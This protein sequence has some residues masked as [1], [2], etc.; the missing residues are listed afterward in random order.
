[1][2][3]LN[4]AFGIHCH[5]PVGS[6][7]PEIDRLVDECYLPFLKAAAAHPAFKW[8]VHFSGALLHQ[9]EPRRPELLDELKKMSSRGQLELLGGGLYEPILSTLTEADQ[10]GQIRRFSDYL[11]R[12]AGVRPTGAWLAK[13][14]WE[15]HLCKPLQEAGIKYLMLDDLNVAAAGVPAEDVHGYYLTEDAGHRVSVFPMDEGIKTLISRGFPAVMDYLEGMADEHPGTLVTY[16]ANG[17]PF[18]ARALEA[19]ILALDRAAIVR[20]TTPA[21]WMASHAP[22][23]P[24]YIPSS[25]SFDLSEEV[26]PSQL[27]KEYEAFKSEVVRHT[28]ASAQRLFLRGGFWRAFLMKYPESNWMQKRGFSASTKMG[29]ILEKLGADREARTIRDLLDRATCNDAYWHGAAGGL[30][31]PH[32]RQAVYQN[33]LEAENRFSKKMGL[34]PRCFS[35]DLDADGQP[36]CLVYTESWVIGLKPAHGAAIVEWSFRPA[37][38]NFQNTLTR[39]SGLAYAL[40]PAVTFDD[41]K[42]QSM[43]EVVPAAGAYESK[44][45]DKPEDFVVRLRRTTPAISFEKHIVISKHESKLSLQAAIEP[46]SAGSKSPACVLALGLELFYVSREALSFRAGGIDSTEGTMSGTGMEIVDR[47]SL[48]RFTA[49]ADRDV[50]FF[51][52]PSYQEKMFQGLSILVVTGESAA[53]GRKDIKLNVEVNSIAGTQA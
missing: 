48:T 10:V 32:L 22:R 2:D 8:C 20:L 26:L 17:L 42:R 25:S 39:R 3:G 9:I 50:R 21:E 5:Q 29:P 13:Q 41:F 7:E 35:D 12:I 27:Q 18:D 6:P 40:D 38:Y 19:F 16:M 14:A 51:V 37:C 36:E 4:L 47:L 33:L 34:F 52:T 1:M 23:G 30:Y 28:R 24:V 44:V 43:P 53:Q 15:P 49:K 31:R 45:D 11:Q 46:K